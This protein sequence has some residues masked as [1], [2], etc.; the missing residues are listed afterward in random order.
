[1]SARPIIIAT[2]QIRR[3]VELRAFEIDQEQEMVKILSEEGVDFETAVLPQLNEVDRAQQEGLRAEAR[4]I[5]GELG[6]F[7][8]LAFESL[9]ELLL[10]VNAT[11]EAFAQARKPVVFATRSCVAP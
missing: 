2:S 8:P 3:E 9:A 1:M 5:C 6:L 4:T 11:D 10:T 7:T